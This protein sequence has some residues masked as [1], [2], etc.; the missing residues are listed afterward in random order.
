MQLM[1]FQEM[2]TPNM[3]NWVLPSSNA[4]TYTIT[5][6]P[7]TIDPKHVQLGTPKGKST[8]GCIKKQ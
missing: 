4:Y 8:L 7:R 1:M 6:V 3:F 5:D 2:Q